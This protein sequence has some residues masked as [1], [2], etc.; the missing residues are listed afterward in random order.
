MRTKSF[1]PFVLVAGCL[2][3]N[4]SGTP[5]PSLNLESLATQSDVIAVGE[6]QDVYPVATQS[7]E[8]RGSEVPTQ[9]LVARMR[10]DRVLKGP[11]AEFLQFRFVLPQFGMGYRGVTAHSYRV[12]FLKRNDDGLELTSPYYPSF[13]A[14]PG[15]QNAGRGPLNSV[16]AEIAAVLESPGALETARTEAVWAL[17]SATST[18]PA[19]HAL[20]VA[21]DSDPSTT[22]K[23]SSV[24]ALLAH[25]NMSQLATAEVALGNPSVPDNL[26]QNL[27]SAIY[28]GVRDP[29]AIP[30]LTRLLATR[31]VRV[32][33]A[34][35]MAL[36]NTGSADAT[37]GL[38]TALRDVDPE[39]RY[40]AVIGLA[41]ITGQTDSRPLQATFLENEELY[42]GHWK[43]WAGSSGQGKF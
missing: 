15:Y 3:G 19:L 14:M 2:I 41:E 31:D 26:R 28:E 16:V 17:R 9:I 10:P 1:W 37:R 25:G 36:R 27:A 22:V 42:I 38:I 35:A 5:I 30:A 24:A 8:I 6:I 32:R 13:P 11:V 29:A 34:A 43:S 7:M 23:L 18:A 40:Y 20:K 12:V 21:A 33:R 4:L 39:V